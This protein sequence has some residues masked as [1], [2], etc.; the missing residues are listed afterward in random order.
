[1][2]FLEAFLVYCLLEDSPP[3]DESTCDACKYNQTNTAKKGRDPEFRLY[4]DDDEV[5]LESWAKEILRD[6]SGVAELIDSAEGGDS[7][8]Q[9]VRMMHGLVEEPMATPS[10]QLL[11]DLKAENCGFFEYAFSVAQSHRDYFASIAPLSDARE[12]EFAQEALR[13]IE[14]QKQIEASDEISLEQYLANYF[15]SD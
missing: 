14:Q 11:E 10:A 5:T 9:A 3:L 6:V 4:R 1:M 13:S 2:R 8:L 12:A 15:S 7:Y